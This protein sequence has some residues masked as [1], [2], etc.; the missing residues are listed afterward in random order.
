MANAKNET[1]KVVTKEAGSKFIEEN[2]LDLFS[3]ENETDCVSKMKQLIKNNESNC[4]VRPSSLVYRSC[5]SVPCDLPILHSMHEEEEDIE[6]LEENE[7]SSKMENCK[8]ES[9]NFCGNIEEEGDEESELNEI[10]KQSTNKK[11]AG[12]EN[13]ALQDMTQN[14]SGSRSSSPTLFA[15]F[16][17]FRNRSR[18]RITS[19]P[20]LSRSIASFNMLRQQQQTSNPIQSS[21]PNRNQHGQVVRNT[22]VRHSSYEYSP[23]SDNGSSFSGND[24]SPVFLRSLPYRSK[25]IRPRVSESLPFTHELFM[26]GRRRSSSPK[27]FSQLSRFHDHQHYHYY[28]QH[29]P[30]RRSSDISPLHQSI[31]LSDELHAFLTSCNCARLR[32][33]FP[34][35]FTL[36]Q[37]RALSEDDLQEE[38]GVSEIKDREDLMRAV[39]RSKEVADDDEEEK[40]RERE[41]DPEFMSPPSSNLHH[42]KSVAGSQDLTASVS[43]SCKIRRQLSDNALARR[44]SICGPITGK[45]GKRDSVFAS[46]DGHLGA[47]FGGETSNLVRMRNKLM[48]NSAPSLTTAVKEQLSSSYSFSRRGS[49]ATPTRNSSNRRS[50]IGLSSTSPTLP[51]PHSPGLSAQV[52]SPMDSPRNVSPNNAAHFSFNSAAGIIQSSMVKTR[53]SGAPAVSVLE[54]RRWSVASLPSSGYGTN[55]PS[56]TLSSSACSSQEGLHQL[57]YQP[58]QEDIHFLSNQFHSN[59]SINE[60]ESG[61]RSPY[62]PRSRSLS[63]GR[64]MSPAVDSE[65]IMM[66]NVYRERFPNAKAEMEEK[67]KDFIDSC[68]SDQQKPVADATWSF[69]HHQVYEM[70]RACLGKSQDGLI[71]ANYFYEL[72]E[73]LEML[74]VDAQEKSTNGGGSIVKLIRKLLMIVARPARLLECLEFNPEEF[75]LLLESAEFVAK[76]G[77][78][79]IETD[80]PRY[81]VQ[82]LGLNKDPVEEMKSLSKHKSSSSESESDAEGKGRDQNRDRMI[83]SED[84][85]VIS[86]LISNGA[87]GAV[88]LVR[89]KETK[90]RFAMKKINKQNLALRNQIEQVF[91]ERDILTFVENPFVVTMYCSFQTKRHLCMVMEYV[92]G[93]DVSTLIKNIGPLPI[94]LAQMYFAETIMALEYLHNYGVVHRDLKPDNLLITSMGHIKLT[95]FGLSKVGLMSLTTNTYET[96]FMDRQIRGTPEYIAPEVIMH[97]G[98]GPPVDWWSAGICLYEFVVG[99][100]PFFGDTPDELFTQVISEEIVWPEGDECLPEDVVDLISQLLDREPERRLGTQGALE[101]KE[102][103]F[104]INLDW[105]SLL[106][107]KAQFIP[108]LDDD[109]DTSYFDNRSE[110]YCHDIGNSDDETAD[111]EIIQLA[112]FT[113][114]TKRYSQTFQTPRKSLNDDK[115]K[116]HLLS[117]AH[118]RTSQ[119]SSNDSDA[120]PPLTARSSISALECE[121]PPLSGV[122]VSSSRVSDVPKFFISGESESEC[123][124]ATESEVKVEV[125]KSDKSTKEDN[126]IGDDVINSIGNDDITELN[127][128]N[129]RTSSISSSGSEASDSKSPLPPFHRSTSSESSVESGGNS[130]L[131]CSR[132]DSGTKILVEDQM[133]ANTPLPSK[134]ETKIEI[135][136]HRKLCQTLSD[137]TPPSLPRNS[138]LGHIGGPKSPEMGS[139]SSIKK[140]RSM[141]A[142]S[143]LVVNECTPNKSGK[144]LTKP[145]HSQGL[146]TPVGPIFTKQALSRSVSSTIDERSHSINTPSPLAL[147]NVSP[148]QIL[149]NNP[150]QRLHTPATH[151]HHHHHKHRYRRLSS[152]STPGSMPHHI[153]NSVKTPSQ[154]GAGAK[155]LAERGIMDQSS[156]I[157]AH[158]SR[159]SPASSNSSGNTSP[160]MSVLSPGTPH[161]SQAEEPLSRHVM[162]S[163]IPDLKHR[164]L[165]GDLKRSRSLKRFMKSSSSSS[166]QLVIPTNEDGSL[167]PSPLA[168]PLAF[169][170]AFNYSNTTAG[171]SMPSSRESSPGRSFSPIPGSPKPQIVIKRAAHGFGFKMQGTPVFFGNKGNSF[172]VHHIVMSVDEKGPAYE[173]GLRVGDLITKINNE[174][175]QGLVHT[176]V[177]EIMYKCKDKVTIQAMPIES[178]SITVGK[179]NKKGK[180]KLVRRRK[181]RAS[182]YPRISVSSSSKNQ[183]GSGSSSVTIAPDGFQ[184]T[185]KRRSSLLRRILPRG[186][187]RGHSPLLTQSRS[188]HAIPKQHNSVSSGDSGPTSPTRSISPRSP[189]HRAREPDFNVSSQSTSPNPSLPESP[190]TTSVA[191]IIISKPIR[192]DGTKS[193]GMSSN[194]ITPIGATSASRPRSLQGIG[195]KLRNLRSSSRR[196]SIG[197]IPLSPLA[198]ASSPSPLSLTDSSLAVPEQAE[199]GNEQETQESPITKKGLERHQSNPETDKVTTIHEENIVATPI[200]T[201]HASTSSKVFNLLKGSSKQKSK[202]EKRSKNLKAAAP[203]PIAE[204]GCE[205]TPGTPKEG[206]KA[207]SAVLNSPKVQSKHKDKTKPDQKDDNL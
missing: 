106:R 175:V 15:M 93:G 135:P 79:C 73:K 125:A 121:S 178:T 204:T 201:K 122:S 118:R 30:H 103:N 94:E 202:P 90:Q 167:P 78:H 113:S 189:P 203:S 38:Y 86:K 36:Q 44:G 111:E 26:L 85:F 171:P 105:T 183:G 53:S 50:L 194:R 28:H 31:L 11:P 48:G 180:G 197:H 144:T 57:P 126:K 97:Q 34:L 27:P 3:L 59:E 17:N 5:F 56:S 33:V 89:H 43:R 128:K 58:T 192:I 146:L 110:R 160:D 191:P 42:L 179:R 124:S 101:V 24:Q 138:L 64:M 54:G 60:D 187:V 149:Q 47:G 104:F 10:N 123:L 164:H 96:V 76:E 102:H 29:H 100:V 99:C 190:A 163:N 95:D 8:R 98:Y 117:N 12:H 20:D 186:E 19:S 71:T 81:I 170:T 92:E 41:S 66:N 37:F 145:A 61:R 107:Q 172:T 88:Y 152:S 74:M 32:G 196:K 165:S 108:S 140:S 68:S 129:D 142:D 109:E 147:S 87:Y 162:L 114:S 185:R 198:R 70:A 199:T 21:L 18:S 49:I 188:L 84:D 6:T 195:H 65:V 168:S 69:V 72:S 120:S 161:G 134:I 154:P 133:K 200:P 25:R 184:Y 132:A 82:Q 115:T 83:V 174:F 35:N 40:E 91:A 52:C 127:K 16:H 136:G 39:A 166:L 63:P 159:S 137:I 205:L 156:F 4:R 130:P 158:S 131:P 1:V 148:T 62:R 116:F 14:E 173:A 77:K 67:L 45:Y 75:Y 9:M 177:L 13:N 2:D 182:F 51:R 181:K 155:M 139:L 176:D 22:R 7:N 157:P 112:N 193:P 141:S 80:I 151:P 143:P 207:N 119:E 153:V 150:T 46:Y 23:N 169:N 55:T 206:G